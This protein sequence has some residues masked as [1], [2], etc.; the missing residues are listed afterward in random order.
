MIPAWFTPLPNAG[1]YL[2]A[3]SWL[4]VGLPL[5]TLSG[6]GRLWA[7]DGQWAILCRSGEIR[8]AAGVGII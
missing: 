8:V 3:T 4:T 1:G 2:V 5:A 6:F 7:T